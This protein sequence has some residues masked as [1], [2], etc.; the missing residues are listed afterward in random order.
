[1]KK[2]RLCVQVFYLFSLWGRGGGDVWEGCGGMG[3]I[4]NFEHTFILIYWISYHISSVIRWSFSFQNN[5]KALDLSCKTDQDLWNCLGR[6]E[7]IL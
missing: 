3:M 5:P 7:L 2:M 1:M 6:V 4:F